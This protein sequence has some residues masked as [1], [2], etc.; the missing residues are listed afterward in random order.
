MVNHNNKQLIKDVISVKCVNNKTLQYWNY[1]WSSISYE[2]LL[3]CHL[4]DNIN[5]TIGFTPPSLEPSGSRLHLAQTN[6]ETQ[7]VR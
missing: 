7:T 1:L 2:V 5:E 6:W 4:L 3:P